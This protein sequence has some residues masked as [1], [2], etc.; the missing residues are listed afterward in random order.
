MTARPDLQRVYLS[1]GAAVNLKLTGGLEQ[2][3]L[4]RPPE[5]GRPEGKAV[6]IVDYFHAC[7]HL[8]RA[9]DAIFGES[10]QRGKIQFTH[11][12]T[13]LKES[14]RGVHQIIAM[15]RY[16]RTR[17]P[18]AGIKAIETEL[19]YFCNQRG[20][21]HYACYRREGWPIGSGV[22]EAACKTLVTQRMKRSGM[23]WSPSGGQ[24]ILTLR[25]WIRSDRFQR[26]WK[27]LTST[28]QTPCKARQ[29]DRPA[30]SRLVI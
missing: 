26:A 8:K 29:T 19:T 13:I 30:R 27:I 17:A 22:V 11:Y 15:L 7:E 1:D 12:K 20:R 6:E 5:E 23:A 24:A 10:T 9:C 28:Y 25:A 2:A 3:L 21:M 14:D 18:S 4:K 16:R